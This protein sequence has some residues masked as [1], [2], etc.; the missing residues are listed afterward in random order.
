[1]LIVKN[2]LSAD[3]CNELNKWVD[4]GVKNNLLDK[5]FNKKREKHNLRLTTR[6]Y[7]NRFKYPAIVYDIFKKITSKLNLNDLIKSSLGGRDGIVVSCTLSG[8]D[9]HSHVDVKES[10][11]E[12]LRCN[13][14]TRSADE[15]GELFIEGNKIDISVG[16]LHC[17]LPS[18]IEHHVTEV[19]GNTSRVLWMFGYQCSI[20][21]FKQLCQYQQPT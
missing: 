5:A 9:V 12:L 2:F 11:L 16:D 13:I 3:E 14:M 17:Y 7:E 8:G 19:K 15:G 10:D 18:L 20:E 1:M 6:L 21:R 4:L